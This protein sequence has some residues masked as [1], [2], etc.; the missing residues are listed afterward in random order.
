[1]KIGLVLGGGGS[2]GSYQVGVIRALNE[3]NL[4]TN[5]TAVSGTSIGALNACLVME[6]LSFLQ[7]REIWQEIHVEDLYKLNKGQKSASDYLGLFDQNSVYE[8][9]IKKQE[10]QAILQSS[11]KGYASVTKVNMFNKKGEKI[12]HLLESKLISLNS[13]K[14]PHK[15]V[16][17]SVSIPALF[18]PTELEGEVYVDGG[19]LNNLPIDGVL[20]EDVDVIFVIGL[21]KKYDL[22]KFN[23][24][25]HLT[26]FNFTPSKRL[27]LTALPALDFSEKT[28]DK[29]IEQGYR[30]AKTLI[31]KLKQKGLIVGKKVIPN[32]QGIYELNKKGELIKIEL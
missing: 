16:L 15:V 25:P 4:L 5:L 14:D 1:M 3:A 30:E 26:V 24:P 9:L 29:W 28:I 32:Q 31:K 2:R 22:K 8:M 11:I 10:K 13:S 6:R 21:A 27:T 20:K 7:M 18:K 19:V 23:L 17:A 12:D